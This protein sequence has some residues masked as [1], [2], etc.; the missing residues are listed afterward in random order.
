[1]SKFQIHS[2]TEFKH[3]WESRL[4]MSDVNISPRLY[5]TIYTP[6][7]KLQTLK[8][9]YLYPKGFYYAW[10]FSH[11]NLALFLELN[12][13][14][15]A[16]DPTKVTIGMAAIAGF[17]NLKSKFFTG[18][19]LAI[20]TLPALGSKPELS[21]VLVPTSQTWLHILDDLGFSVP[22]P[23]AINLT[24]RYSRLGSRKDVIDVYS[25][26]SGLPRKTLTSLGYAPGKP[27]TDNA[28]NAF[29]IT[30]K[31]Q[32]EYKKVIQALGNSPYAYNNDEVD[33]VGTISLA[34]LARLPEILAD[35]DPKKDL[36][37]MVMA[38]RAALA[39]NQDASALCTLTG[40]GYNTYPNP[41]VCKP[42]SQQTIKQRYTGR[43]FILLN[44][45]L[46]QCQ[47][48]TSIKLEVNEKKKRKYL[49]KGWC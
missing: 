45:R 2:P 36:N 35:M 28:W 46:E 44:R 6:D 40:L 37:L 21:Q 48:H 1:M 10:A 24:R 20:Y 23:V 41:F 26:L 32:K 19:N 27:N 9:N 22:L 43:E 29:N 4:G 7:P 30:G 11:S 49:K 42:K 34:G 15:G 25:K 33:K 14:Y 3:A 16:T 47:E 38:T 17:P 18:G 31:R 8:E 5:A 12:K 39:Q 13:L